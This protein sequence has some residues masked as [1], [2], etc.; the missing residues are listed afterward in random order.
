MHHFTIDRAVILGCQVFD[1][2]GHLA[3]EANGNA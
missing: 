2:F 3:R 1:G